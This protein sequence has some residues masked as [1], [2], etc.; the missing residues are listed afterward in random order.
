MPFLF[1]YSWLC[2]ISH[3]LLSSVG[4]FYSSDLYRLLGPKVLGSVFLSIYVLLY[5]FNSSSHGFKGLY[6]SSPDPFSKLETL[7]STFIHDFLPRVLYRVSNFQ[8]PGAPL[9]L[10]PSVFSMSLNRFNIYLLLWA[11]C[12]KF[13]HNLFCSHLYPICWPSSNILL[14]LNMWSFSS[15]SLTLACFRGSFIL[16]PLSVP[17]SFWVNSFPPYK[18]PHL[19]NHSTEYL[20]CLPFLIIK[21][22][23]TITSALKSWY[24]NTFLPLCR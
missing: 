16:Q 8:P 3:P 18:Y 19:L 6:P 15:D 7:K 12:E 10:Y 5:Q 9:N 20:D 23:A 21:N 13:S 22:N 17:C 1:P 14:Y 2:F 24:K 4:L 11:K